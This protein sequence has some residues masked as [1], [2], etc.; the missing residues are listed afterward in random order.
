MMKIILGSCPWAIDTRRVPAFFKG[1]SENMLT[2]EYSNNISTPIEVQLTKR[3]TAGS[4]SAS[5]AFYFPSAI[6]YLRLIRCQSQLIN[7]VYVY[8]YRIKLIHKFTHRN[9]RCLSKN[10]CSRPCSYVLSVPS[11]R[12]L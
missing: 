12:P 7:R 11:L 5:P 6:I 8:P 3:Q 4:L 1:E 2:H 9:S 10:V